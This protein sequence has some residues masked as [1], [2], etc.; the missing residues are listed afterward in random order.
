MKHSVTA[1]AICTMLAVSASYCSETKAAESYDSH[2]IVDAYT[3]HTGNCVAMKCKQ[4]TR[5]SYQYDYSKYVLTDIGY[6]HNSYGRDS[7]NIGAAVT[8]VVIGQ[9]KL[10]VFATA[11]SGYSCKELKTCWIAGGLTGILD[12]ERVRVQAIYTPNFGNK[13]QAVWQ[14]R[15][16]W[17]Y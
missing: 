3:R 1:T 10:G 8:P 13:T 2:I 17:S 9:M 5:V 11:I 4:P 7:F 14:I 12:V 15:L 16:G 6:G